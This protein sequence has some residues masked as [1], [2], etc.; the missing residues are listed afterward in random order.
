[1]KEITSYRYQAFDGTIFENRFDCVNYEI[2]LA[3]NAV[4]HLRKFDIHFPMQ[5]AHVNHRAYLIL[6]ENEFAM[7][8]QCVLNDHIEADEEYIEYEGNG[9][10]V[11]QNEDDTGWARVVKLSKVIDELNDTL[12]TISKNIFDL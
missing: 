10:Y 1:M 12:N 7:F 9:W 8:K 11:V 3:N 4:G 6:S 2:N 5:Q